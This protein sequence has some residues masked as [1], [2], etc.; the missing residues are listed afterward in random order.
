M[1]RKLYKTA[2]SPEKY[3]GGFTWVYVTSWQGT[4]QSCLFLQAKGKTL[5][6][7]QV[8]FSHWMHMIR[9][10][11]FKASNG[12]GHDD[13]HEQRLAAGRTRLCELLRNYSRH[14]NEPTR[15][16]PQTETEELHSNVP[17]SFHFLGF[18]PLGLQTVAS[19]TLQFPSPR[20]LGTGSTELALAPSCGDTGAHS[21]EQS[22]ENSIFKTYFQWKLKNR[23]LGTP[24]TQLFTPFPWTPAPKPKYVSKRSKGTEF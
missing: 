3:K 11:A 1:Q 12:W 17:F 16:Y 19:S 5:P 13:F 18:L 20:F 23:A 14:R 2:V 7:S 22:L 15:A 9:N 6:S 10:K 24:T 8:Q 4:L 21:H